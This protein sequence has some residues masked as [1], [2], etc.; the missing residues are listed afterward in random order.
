MLEIN[1]INVSYGKVEVIKDVSLRVNEGEIVSIIGA[2]GAGKTTI[3]NTISGLLKPTSG[4]IMFEGSDISTQKYRADKIVKC[5]LT[6]CPQGRQ[7]FPFHTVHQNLL[8]GGYLI[9]RDK[10]R[11]N[12]Q[13]KKSY[14]MFPILEERSKQY[15]GTLSGGEQQMLAI[16]RAMMIEP[17]LLLLDEPSAGLAPVYVK[18]VFEMAKRLAEMGTTILLV[19]QMANMALKI[20]DRA[21]VLETGKIILEGTG[22]EVKNNPKVIESY[23]GGKK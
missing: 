16:A 8:L 3:M 4:T 2:N 15:A 6:M 10:K 9:N 21:Y 11:L 5:G 14:E 22:E 19:E 13:L 20:S 7:I 12:E 18:G 17:K 23:L 1:N